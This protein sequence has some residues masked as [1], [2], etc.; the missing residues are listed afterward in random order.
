MSDFCK[1]YKQK[2]IVSY[3]SGTTWQ[4][5]VPAVYKMGGLYESC[6]SD[7]GYMII[8]RWVTDGTVCMGKDLYEFQ[9]QQISYDGGITFNDTP[10]VRAGGLVG[11][12][13]EGCG[14]KLTVTYIGGTEYAADCDLELTIDKKNITD[15]G[16]SSAVTSAIIGQCVHTIN[17][18]AF[19]GCSRLPSIII[20]DNITDI[21]KGAFMRCHSLS[22]VTMSDNIEAISEYCFFEDSGL[23]SI[24]LPSGL[25]SIGDW[26]FYSCSGLTNVVIP[27]SVEYLGNQAFYYCSSLSAVTLPSGITR[28][29]NDVFNNCRSLTSIAL[30]ETVER[31]GEAAFYASGLQEIDIPSGVTRIDKSAFKNCSALTSV[32]I[33]AITPPTLRA[34]AFDNTNNCPIYV[35]CESVDDYK[36][37]SGWSTYASRITSLACPV[38]VKLY[39]YDAAPTTIYCPELSGQIKYSDIGNDLDAP[40]TG[41][42]GNSITQA[43]IGDCVTELFATFYYCPRLSRVTFSSGS[44]LTGL[45]EYLRPGYGTYGVFQ[46]CTGLTSITLPNSLDRIGRNCFNGCTSLSSVTIPNSVTEIGES[47]FTNCTS[48][49]CEYINLPDNLTEIKGHVFENCTSFTSIVIPSTI[50]TIGNS[51][52]WGCSSLSSITVNAITPPT[53]GTD[54]FYGT[55]NCPIYVPCTSLQAYKT[56]WSAYESRIQCNGTADYRLVSTATTC[57]GNDRHYVD[58]YQVSYNSG[59][60]W[61][62]ISTEV[63]E[64]IEANSECCGSTEIYEKELFKYANGDYYI[65]EISESHPYSGD[66]SVTRYDTVSLDILGIT[67]RQHFSAMTSA[68]LGDVVKVIET[69]AFNANINYGGSKLETVYIGTGITQ[70]K[71]DN[72]CDCTKLESVV[73]N[74]TTPPTLGARCFTGTTCTIYVPCESLQAYKTAWPSLSSRI[75]PI[76]DYCEYKFKATYL[77]GETYSAACD[78]STT[79]TQTNVRQTG[80]VYSAMTSVSIGNCTWGIGTMAFRDCKS[81]SSVTIGDGVVDIGYQAF[82]N[83]TSLTSIGKDTCSSL[84]LPYSLTDIGEEAFAFCTSLKTVV[85]P[86]TVRELHHNVFNG[87]YNL[88]SI[89][90]ESATPPD[91]GSNMPLGYVRCP[92]YVPSQSVDLYKN[93][94]PWDNYANQ[95]YGFDY[96]PTSSA[97]DNFKA[98]IRYG[99]NSLYQTTIEC[100]SDLILTSGETNPMDNTISAATSAVIGNCTRTIGKKAFYGASNLLSLVISNRVKSIGLDAFVGCSSLTRI[101]IPSGVTSISEGAFNKCS[102][103]TSITV[104]DA[105]AYYDS[106]NNCNAIIATYSGTEPTIFLLQG[107]STTIIP[108][109][110]TS[111]GSAF[112]GCTGLTN[113]NIP[114][115]VKHIGSD[116]FSQCS[117]ITGVTI[118]SGV[119][120][121]GNAAFYGCE[122]LSSITVPSSVTYIDSNAFMGC[123]SLTSF[124]IPNGVTSVRSGTFRGCTGL[125]SV[126]IP[127]GVTNIGSLSFYYCTSLTSVTL[128][129]SVTSIEQQS[130]YNCRSLTSITINAVTPPT[131]G[132]YALS[133]TNGCPIYVP[134]GSVNVYKEDSAWGNF[135]SRIFPIP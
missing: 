121:I 8:K 130:F 134:A 95:I 101:D 92:I 11:T 78:S 71:S 127:Y 38:S 3:D 44:T 113:I 51:A 32:T 36:A 99:G 66:S 17:E 105:N 29:R 53:L 110:V 128:P 58:E 25:T 61:I 102:S 23:T 120:R 122:S 7:C 22:S 37:A 107:C 13:V 118:G 98:Q 83:C 89:K 50:D 47:A 2:K 57:V 79:I 10:I 5:V 6:S 26:A 43:E 124:T 65:Y 30:P 68:L 55:G 88:E 62:T 81:L 52:F 96:E 90:I 114:N 15:G 31:I 45:T 74:A 12:D 14:A 40:L 131:L 119:T 70:I 72:F 87:C 19:S 4:D 117:N 54:A 116:A 93:T 33:N 126:T 133:N 108:D 80:Y 64:L 104:S 60:T 76:N 18:Y 20:P 91:A 85:I 16:N 129:S 49:R 84:N 46:G 135:A 94:Y 75:K 132:S 115:K 59:Q 28:V 86:S 125:T 67:G 111:I 21:N 100:N 27:D 48:L 24:N 109:S 69:S 73:I 42:S 35:P 9:K 112:V 56:A 41:D 77:S 34:N 1:H 123:S 97:K 63:G 39:F 106:R 103:L 82:Y